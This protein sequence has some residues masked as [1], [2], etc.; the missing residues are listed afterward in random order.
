[1]IVVDGNMASCSRA[2]HLGRKPSSGG[3]PPSDRS[4]RSSEA[5]DRAGVGN[6][7]SD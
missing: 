2:S 7:D 5:C 1:M 6:S 4:I 3:R